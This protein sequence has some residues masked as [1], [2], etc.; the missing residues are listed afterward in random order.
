MSTPLVLD[1][2]TDIMTLIGAINQGQTPNPSEQAQV[3]FAINRRLDQWNGDSLYIYGVKEIS[4]GLLGNVQSVQIGSSAAAPWNVQRPFIRHARIAIPGSTVQLPLQMI[5]SGEWNAIEEPGLSGNRPQK[6]FVDY[7]W[8][9]ANMRFWPIP[10]SAMTLYLEIWAQISQFNTIT[11]PV[12]FPPGYLLPFEYMV[13]SDV[14]PSFQRQIEP[15]T[16]Q[17]IVTNAA[18]AAQK[19]QQLNSQLVQ[20]IASGPVPDMKPPMAG[21]QPIPVQ[22]PGPGT[23][24]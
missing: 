8:P 15:T 22:A 21:D 13:A 7:N 10:A 3:F 12:V 17:N 11:D 4:G 18:G 5:S 9:V 6:M 1:L 24:Q 20:G 19:I 23:P 2:I 16:M 14:L